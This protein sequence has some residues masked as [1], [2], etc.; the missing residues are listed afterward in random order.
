[1]HSIFQLVNKLQTVKEFN[2]VYNNLSF[3]YLEWLISAIPY[4][5]GSVC[6]PNMIFQNI[7][8]IFITPLKTFGFYFTSIEKFNNI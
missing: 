2:F 5:E 8:S 4:M 3:F 1:M 6:P 7:F